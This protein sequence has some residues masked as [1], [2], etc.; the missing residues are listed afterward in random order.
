VRS[1]SEVEAMLEPNL[2][3]IRIWPCKFA[4]RN[5]AF[6]DGALLSIQDYGDLFS[7]I[8]VYYGGDGVTN[9]ALPDLRSR[10]PVHFAETYGLGTRGGAEQVALAA[11]DLP[12]HHHALRTAAR[13]GNAAV[14]TGAMI[15]ADEATDKEQAFSYLPYA[16]ASQTALAPGSVTMVGGGKA[17]DNVQ[18]FLAINYIISLTGI[19]PVRP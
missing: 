11:A 15:L 18:P 2:G 13:P 10:V 6:C 8:D 3:D 14:P 1:A 7:L 4:P 17:H 5:W 19:Y 9:F 12:V 16:S